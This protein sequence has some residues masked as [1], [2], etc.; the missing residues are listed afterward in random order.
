[1]SWFGFGG[2]NRARKKAAAKAQGALAEFYQRD[3]K[4]RQKFAA[5]ASK[6]GATNKSS[7]ASNNR[8]TNKSSD[9]KFATHLLAVDI[10][11]TGF[12]PQTDRMLSIGWVPITNGAIELEGAG[13]VVLG[14]KTARQD[15][16][17]ESATIHG[18]TDDMLAEGVSL[19]EGLGIFLQA[20]AGRTMLAHFAELETKFL[21]HACEQQFG[22]PLIVA[23]VDTMAREYDAITTTGRDPGRDELRLWNLRETYGLPTYKAHHA[24]T[25]ALACAELWI[26]QAAHRR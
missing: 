21:N 19:E 10:E 5:S 3:E 14:S 18:I 1:M 26:A 23:T 16:V 17:G 20:L 9:P 7:K 11:T 25:D 4:L 2:K 15:S 8:A 13:H 22:A 6:S 24:L 12:D